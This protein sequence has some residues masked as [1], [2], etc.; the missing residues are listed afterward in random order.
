[1]SFTIYHIVCSILIG[2]LLGCLF[3]KKE[4]FIGYDESQDESGAGLDIN[5]CDLYN[6]SLVSSISPTILESNKCAFKE[7][8][9][10]V[11]MLQ[12]GDDNTWSWFGESESIS[13]QNCKQCIQGSQLENTLV[14]NIANIS[15]EFASHYCD[16]LFAECD[17]HSLYS[18][19]KDNWSSKCDTISNKTN[20]QEA[21][22]TIDNPGLQWI[23]NFINSPMCDLNIEALK[24]QRTFTNAISEVGDFFEEANPFG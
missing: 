10:G 17:N 7:L 2:Y 21:V 15:Q 24:I 3:K 11:A 19:S 5:E 14:T 6:G 23:L 16:A 20:V 9:C 13:K 8:D 1:M 22:C 4:G 12:L 18:N